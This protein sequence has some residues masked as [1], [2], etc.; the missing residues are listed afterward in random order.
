MPP[1]HGTLSITIRKTGQEAFMKSS[2]GVVPFSQL[3]ATSLNNVVQAIS[4]ILHLNRSYTRSSNVLQKDY[5]AIPY[6]H[7]KHF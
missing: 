5:L 6:Y 3:Q 4:C 1:R 2:W 7:G